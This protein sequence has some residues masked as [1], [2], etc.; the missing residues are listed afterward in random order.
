MRCTRWCERM[1]ARRVP[2]VL[3]VAAGRDRWR[4][5]PSLRL[6][7]LIVPILSK[8]APLLREQIPLLAERLNHSLVPWLA[9]FGINVSLDTESIKAFVLKYAR[10]QH[11]GLA[12]D[13]AG[14]GAHR[15]QLHAGASSAMRCWCRWC[16]STC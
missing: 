7:L 4:S 9:Q 15:R 12:G 3:A 16:C 8:Q 10:R 6:L 2:R 11:R 13:G 14:L 5:S 1:V